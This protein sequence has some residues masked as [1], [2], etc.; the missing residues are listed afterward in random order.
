LYDQNGPLEPRRYSSG[1]TQVDLIEEVLEAFDESDVVFLKATVGSGKSVIGIRTILEFGRGIV[2]VPTKVLSDQYAA[3]YERDKYFLKKNGSKAKIGILKGRRNFACMLNAEKGRKTSCAS[4]TLPCTR[5]LDKEAEERRVDAVQQCPHWGFVFHSGWASSIKD[6]LKLPYEGIAGKW[7]WCMKGECPYWKQFQAYAYSDAIVM[8]SMKW[9]AE[10][11]IGRLPRVPV[12]V[13]DEADE[14]LDSLAVK[15]LLTQKR[16]D[17]ARERIKQDEELGEK[18]R[19]MWAG[20]LEGKENPLEMA[21]FLS[22]V[23]EEIDETSGDLYWKLKSLLEHRDHAESEVRGKTVVYF[24][25]DPKI[26]LDRLIDKVGGKWLLMSATCVPPETVIMTQKPKPVGE[27][28]TKELV[29]GKSGLTEVLNTFSRHYDGKLIEIIPYSLPPLKM[30]P[31]HPVLAVKRPECVWESWRKLGKR[32]RPDCAQKNKCKNSRQNR[33]NFKP[34]WIEAGKLKKGDCVLFPKY[35]ELNPTTYIDLGKYVPQPDRMIAYQEVI[36]LRK[37]HG[38]GAKRLSE[39]VGVPASAVE[40]WIYKG[41]SPGEFETKNSTIHTK[42]GG[43]KIN[44]KIYVDQKLMEICGWYISEGNTG[45]YRVRFSLGSHERKAVQRLVKLIKEKFGIP[46]AQIL[47]GGDHTLKVVFNSAVMANF[48]STNFGERA[49]EKRIPEWILKLPHSFLKKLLL[50]MMEGDGYYSRNRGKCGTYEYSTSSKTLAHQLILLGSKIDVLPSFAV[51]NRKSRMSL[52]PRYKISFLM[53]AKRRNYFKD[54]DFYY[55]QI[56]KIKSEE[57]SG[58]VCNLETTDRTYLSSF[59]V[60]NCQPREVLEN[61]FGISPT[62]VEGETR[63]PG[64]LVQRKVGREEVVNY[65]RWADEKFRRRYWGLLSGMMRK[66]KRPGFVPVHAFKYLPQKLRE[67]IAAEGT[68]IYRQRGIVFTTKMDRGADLK[69]M[70]SI[71]VTK[72]PYPER[73]DPLLKGMER[74][75][76]KEAFWDY[77]RDMAERSFV[78]QVGRVLRSDEDVVE[79]WSPDEA[80]HAGL[81]SWKGSILRE[82]VEEGG[83]D[84]SPQG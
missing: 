1:K 36:E 37:T 11:S 49:L 77:Y 25:P 14:W 24:I 28:K 74:R 34:E 19:R 82:A 13:I 76:G 81:R 51:D 75:L 5:P 27:I 47:E 45:S 17:W 32:C 35:D 50:T 68:D 63:F 58:T 79:F 22:E 78:Q 21:G 43:K 38:W 30:T 23:L 53:K 2:S 6:A 65:R 39:A 66:A 20:T 70:R 72:F 40:Y 69:G 41:K 84:V 59:L 56:R 18:L 31:D 67:K 42:R 8:N 73:E 44:R 7:I 52:N 33:E 62:F 15:V 46:P 16:V 29:I 48:F 3:S 9:A 71:I 64:E 12:T 61:V 10:V 60:H 83:P 55:V 57:Y 80:C 54:K 26:V 4:S